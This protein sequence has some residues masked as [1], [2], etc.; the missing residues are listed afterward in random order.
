[1]TQSLLLLLFL[2]LLLLLL[3]Q[4]PLH[5]Q[6]LWGEKSCWLVELQARLSS[7][8]ATAAAEAALAAVADALKP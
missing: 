8:A 2:L 7:E 6:P 1:M 5:K 4:D 3:M